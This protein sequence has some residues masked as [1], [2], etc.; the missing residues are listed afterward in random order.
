MQNGKERSLHFGIAVNDGVEDIDV[1]GIDEAQFFDEG[2]AE[3]CETLANR[4]IR[5]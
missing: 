2:I 1:V 5:A 3:V 4:G